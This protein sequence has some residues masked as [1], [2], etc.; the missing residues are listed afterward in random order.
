M[1]KVKSLLLTLLAAASL[2]AFAGCSASNEITE[3]EGKAWAEA[4]GYVKQEEP[5]DVDTFTSAS[6]EN[7]G[8]AGLFEEGQAL[9]DA[10]TAKK[11][12]T[13]LATNNP[14]GT[15]N[16]AYI[17][18]SLYEENGKW[19]I[20]AGI[21]GTHDDGTLCQTAQN[22][23]REGRGTAYFLSHSYAE[24]MPVFANVTGDA[25][26]EFEQGK[27]YSYAART[28]YT[29]LKEA[30]EDWATNY[31]AYFTLESTSPVALTD[32]ADAN[33]ASSAKMYF[34]YVSH[35]DN[36]RG[37]GGN[38]FILEVVSFERAS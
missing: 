24:Q 18:F 14:D 9:K 36:G 30:P 22:I 26:P 7:T 37:T 32:P 29:L 19:Y 11:G 5:V 13:V 38:T 15:I 28:D 16:M 31:G 8:F 23:I 21:G 35:G 10:M 12:V 4:N 3:E 2:I 6:V 33:V 20:N 27:Y 1:K 34:N 17:R 25:A